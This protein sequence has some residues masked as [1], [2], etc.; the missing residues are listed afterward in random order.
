M[1][2]EN[3][4][5]IF[6]SQGAGFLM[7]HQRMFRQAPRETTQTLDGEACP[8]KPF[9]EEKNRTGVLSAVEIRFGKC[10]FAARGVFVKQLAIHAGDRMDVGVEGCP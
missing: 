6:V 7:A 8:A 4:G 3:S 9:S 2:H 10:A 5:C 1:L